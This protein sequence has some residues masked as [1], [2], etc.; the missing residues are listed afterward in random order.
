[1]AVNPNK[2]GTLAYTTW[3]KNQAKKQAAVVSPTTPQ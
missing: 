1:M 2:P 3:E